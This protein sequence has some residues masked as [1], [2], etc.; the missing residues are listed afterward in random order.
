MCHVRS[1]RRETS[2]SFIEELPSS[3]NMES[4][5]GMILPLITLILLQGFPQ[6]VSSGTKHHTTSVRTN[7]RAGDERTWSHLSSPNAD[8][9]HRFKPNGRIDSDSS[10]SRSSYF[11]SINSQPHHPRKH[12]R[13]MRTN[14][15]NSLHVFPPPPL[16]MS[17]L[18]RFP[19][20]LSPNSRRHHR[21]VSLAVTPITVYSNEALNSSGESSPFPP[22]SSP[23]SLEDDG[24]NFEVD[25]ESPPPRQV[26][27]LKREI[28]PGWAYN[29][30]LDARCRISN[31]GK[32]NPFHYQTRTCAE[33]YEYLHPISFEKK[34]DK[35]L[36]NIT[37]IEDQKWGKYRTKYLVDP[38]TNIPGPIIFY[39]DT[40]EDT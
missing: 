4:W 25:G 22:T 16:N 34:E 9:S 33:C 26:G 18:P 38:A 3:A 37:L 10:L 21:D 28:D 13:V 2:S 17:N 30:P 39:K 12:G 11:P 6:S 19:R 32:L 24:N 5:L 20:H 31:V 35:F 7:D 40:P 23:S 36:I 14:P 8:V 15:S 1:D 27:T 29:F